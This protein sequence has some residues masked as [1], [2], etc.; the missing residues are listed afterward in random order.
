MNP[1]I[2]FMASGAGRVLRAVAGLA[3]IGV[4]LAGLDGADGNAA[5]LAVAAVG[6]VPLAA[7]VFDFCLLAAVFGKP[8]SGSRIRGSR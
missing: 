2:G 6:L 1:V 4:G 7:G 8:L 3:L 5:G